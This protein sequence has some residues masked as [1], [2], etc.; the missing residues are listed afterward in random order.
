MQPLSHL[1]PAVIYLHA[2]IPIDHYQSS[3]LVEECGGEG[4]S[5][6]H[7]RD[8]DAALGM[9]VRAIEIRDSLA[10]L[11]ELAGIEQRVPDRLDPGRV[12]DGLSVRRGIFL[13]VKIA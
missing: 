2:A 13:A 5:E 12:F 9:S 6:F 3:G 4:N 11:V 1:R 7:R 10:P 8:G